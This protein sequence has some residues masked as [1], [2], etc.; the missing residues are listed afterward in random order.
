M[1]DRASKLAPRLEAYPLFANYN[2]MIFQIA[3]ALSM[4]SWIVK[5]SMLTLHGHKSSD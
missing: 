1:S 2:K 4:P 5:L 3:I